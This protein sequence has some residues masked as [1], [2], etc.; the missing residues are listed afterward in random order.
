MKL[1]P[2]FGASK[3]AFWVSPWR[4]NFPHKNVRKH[5]FINFNNY[6]LFLKYQRNRLQVILESYDR[7]GWLWSRKKKILRFFE[8]W[9]SNLILVPQKKLF[10]F[11]H[12]DEISLKNVEKHF[13]ITFNNYA[14][15][16]K[17]QGNRL[18]VGSESYDSCG[19]L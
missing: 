15:L 16:Q 9:C 13:F 4:W 6:K 3:K 19:W 17:Y 14:L 18:Q 2:H 11:P 1:R 7:C 12:D 10:E 5:F 8:K